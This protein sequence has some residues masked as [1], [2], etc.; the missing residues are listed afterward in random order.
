MSDWFVIVVD[1]QSGYSFLQQDKQVLRG[2]LCNQGGQAA[3]Q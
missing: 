2:S 1:S 3:V